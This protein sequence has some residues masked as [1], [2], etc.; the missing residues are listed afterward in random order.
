MTGADG[1]G[2]P[3]AKDQ[4]DRIAD[5]GLYR[6]MR[7]IE[8]AQGPRVQL[9]GREVLLLCSNNYL[10]LAE[11]PRVRI[12]GAQA[13]RDWGAG[14]GASRLISGNM[15]P[16]ERLER[17]LASFH[18]QE[19]ALL[20][21]SGYLANIGVIGAIARKGQVVYS[22]ELNH[23]SIIDG[24]RLAGAA[25]FVYRHRDLE[26]LAWAMDRMAGHAGLVVTDGLFSMDGDVAPLSWLLELARKHGARLMVDEAHAVGTYGPGGRGTCADAGLA[27]EVDVITGTLGK[28]LGS[29]GAY[30]ACS[31]DVRELLVNTA[32]TEI[33]STGLPPAAALAAEAALEVIEGEPERVR[34]LRRNAIV[35][36]GALRAEGLDI[37]DSVS[38]IVPIMIG[39]PER[40]MAACARILEQGIYTQA[41]RPPT[42]PEGGSRLRVSVMSSHEPE[43]LIAAARVIGEAHRAVSAAGDWSI[44]LPYTDESDAVAPETVE[45]PVPADLL[46]AEADDP[47]GIQITD[48]RIEEPEAEPSHA[49]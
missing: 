33:F 12:A 25:T 42:V 6:R 38:H 22:D 47:A 2:R 14:T 34:T 31:N 1:Q 45:P 26:H 29:Y 4:L 35:M 36:K 5:A 16:H 43:E 28:S 37:G 27:G 7:T 46:L 40:A 23:A 39:E 48:A 20:F 21:G 49:D 9:D 18:E 8:G 44:D 10:G 32:R 17:R 24:C 11:H 3:S 13:Y 30:A 41:I 15:E 19:A